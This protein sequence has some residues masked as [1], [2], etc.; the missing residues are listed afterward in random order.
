MRSISVVVI[1]KNERGLADTLDAI[2]PQAAAIGAEIVVVD[3]SDGRMNDIQARHPDVRWI[4]FRSRTGKTITIPEQRNLGVA[5]ATGEIVVYTDCGCIPAEGWLTR[6]TAPIVSG[7]EHVVTGGFGAVNPG[8]YDD[9]D[10][11]KPTVPGYVD[12]CATGNL[13]FTR[14]AFDAVDGFDENFEYGSDMDFSWRIRAHGFKIR[15]EPSAV[16]LVDWG[17]RRRQ[18]KRS[19]LWGAGRAR[20]YLKHR[21]RISS[22]LRRDPTAVIYPGFLLGLPVLLLT[23]YL[24]WLWLYPAL[25]LVPLWR[26]RRSHPLRTLASHLFYGAGFLWH[27]GRQGWR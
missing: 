21:D 14:H 12:E 5:A 17:D 16:I 25:L 20:L 23:G 24:P 11:G 3:A 19:L 8:I 13:A 9:W 4:P 10:A 26:N 15:R 22:L 6:L 7:D 2:R 27:V 18:F 1:S